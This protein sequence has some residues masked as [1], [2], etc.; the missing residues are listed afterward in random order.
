LLTYLLTSTTT[1]TTTT[2]SFCSISFFLHSLWLGCV[3]KTQ[4]LAVAAAD[5]F[6][7]LDAFPVIQPASSK[8]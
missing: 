8:H 4:L 6:Y 5:F 2:F 3:P 7:R 1:T